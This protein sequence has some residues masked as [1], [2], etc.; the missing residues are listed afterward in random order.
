MKRSEIIE[1][2]ADTIIA[3]MCECYRDVVSSDGR[4]QYKLY[5]WD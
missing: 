4:V 2:Y 5:I 3:E 1:A